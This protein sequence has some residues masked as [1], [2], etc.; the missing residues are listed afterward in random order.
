VKKS[1]LGKEPRF[2]EDWIGGRGKAIVLAVTRKRL[3]TD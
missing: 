3:V 1:S 2:R